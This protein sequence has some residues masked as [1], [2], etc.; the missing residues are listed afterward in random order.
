MSRVVYADE[1]SECGDA[2]S[3]TMSTGRKYRDW[4]TQVDSE[5]QQETGYN[6]DSLINAATLPRGAGGR[7]GRRG[8]K[9]GRPPLP[10]REGV[11][12]LKLISH[13]FC[14]FFFLHIYF[15]HVLK[16]INCTHAFRISLTNSMLAIFL[17]KNLL[18]SK[19]KKR[20]KENTNL[21]K[22]FI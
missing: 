20:T 1:A 10:N 15:P 16:I 4:H 19:A 17:T 22:S 14:F 8:W 2:A 5:Q 7:G 13:S 18:F 6:T 21:K 9:R 12:K 3:S 11:H